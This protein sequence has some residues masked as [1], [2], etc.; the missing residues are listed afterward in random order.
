MLQRHQR[1]LVVLACF[2]QFGTVG[3]T[4]RLQLAVTPA[5]LVGNEGDAAGVAYQQDVAAL[6]PLA[7]KLGELQLHHHGA[8]EAAMLVVHRAGEE[9][10][11]HATGHAHGVKA[12]TAL[13]AGLLE[14]GPEAV[15]GTDVAAG[16]PPV[17]GGDGQAGAVKQFERGGIC[18]AVDAFELA[19]QG[20]LHLF[21][22]RVAQG[23]DQFRVQRQHGGQGAVAVYQ[24][25]QGIGVQAQLLAG[26]PGVVF[27][28]L[29]LGLVHGP[30]GT[31]GGAQHDQQGDQPQTQGA[32]GK[33]HRGGSG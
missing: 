11:R 18:G 7:F 9:V 12:A 33:G 14:V 10:A 17:A 1:L 15:V 21:A 13:A 30:P 5:V 24:G 22:D 6:A 3:T 2:G 32:K 16:Q 8:E 25:V 19:V 20:V 31:E 4:E 26:T 27:H 28:G 23:G 29:A